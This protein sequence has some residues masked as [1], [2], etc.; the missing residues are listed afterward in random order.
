MFEDQQPGEQNN[1]ENQDLNEGLDSSINDNNTPNN[2][3]ILNNL[4]E[5]NLD[6]IKVDNIP[7]P[8]PEKE[9][10]PESEPAKE[11]KPEEEFKEF[12]HHTQN[13]TQEPD[14]PVTVQPVQ[15][16]SFDEEENVHGKENRNLDLLMNV[17]LQ[18][19]VELGRTELPFKK[20][21]ELT[22]GSIISLDKLAG[23][24]V[25]LFANGKL[26]AFGEVVVIEDNF[27][28]RI[29]SI[30][31]PEERLKTVHETTTSNEKK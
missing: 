5:L 1:Q 25:E 7:T 24:P 14:T 26:V 21:L 29:T 4:N 11:I 9:N 2:N 16:T 6:E 8:A 19:S 13:Q 20:V 23:E 27:G 3:D 12:H 28:L 18:M 15:F 30:A 10:I 31:A 17:N 22:R